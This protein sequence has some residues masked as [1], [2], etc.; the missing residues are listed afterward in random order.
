MTPINDM[1]L[2]INIGTLNGYPL[3]TLEGTVT[4]W[5]EQTVEDVI[6]NYLME[7]AGSITLDLTNVGLS[8]A[9]SLSMFIRMLRLTSKQA[10]IAVVAGCPIASVLNMAKLGANVDIL[11]TLAEASNVPRPIPEFL[12]SRRVSKSQEELE[13]PLAA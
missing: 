11:Q 5:H 9:E 4:S 10:H 7:G 2:A 13:L 6:D 8:D 12:T 1:E 3:I